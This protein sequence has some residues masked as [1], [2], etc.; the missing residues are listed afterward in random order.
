MPRRTAPP[1]T[2][3]DYNVAFG[4]ILDNPTA[5][6]LALATAILGALHAAGREVFVQADTGRMIQILG[7]RTNLVQ[8]FLPGK[9]R[10]VRLH[11]RVAGHIEFRIADSLEDK[12]ED[13]V[14]E[15]WT[16]QRD[17]A[18]TAAAAWEKLH[19]R[20]LKKRGKAFSRENHYRPSGNMMPI[21]RYHQRHHFRDQC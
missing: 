6:K 17:N 4:V 13:A 9:L 1:F 11:Q 15:R 12:M 14:Q 8:G 21:G 19:K 18:E 7:K 3:A 20:S 16:A 5:N 2:D 10:G